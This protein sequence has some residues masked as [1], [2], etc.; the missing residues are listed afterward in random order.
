MII[1][2]IGVWS[3]R[4]GMSDLKKYY[5]ERANSTVREYLELRKILIG[6]DRHDELKKA[7]IIYA[8]IKKITTV[9]EKRCWIH[10][11]SCPELDKMNDKL[12]LV[13]ASIEEL[14]LGG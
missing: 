13:C 5:V 4:K 10:S 7:D 1:G 6:C 12:Q 9:Y 3:N 14:K 2:F 11:D 8:D